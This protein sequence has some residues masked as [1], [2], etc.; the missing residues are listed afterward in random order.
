[1]CYVKP[2]EG[3]HFCKRPSVLA[4]DVTFNGHT[5]GQGQINVKGHGHMKIVTI[6]HA[7]VVIQ[8]HL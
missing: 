8:L 7:I 2:L 3:P 6:L 5:Q 1:M 4:H